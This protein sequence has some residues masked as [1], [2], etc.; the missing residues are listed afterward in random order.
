MSRISCLKLPSSIYENE[1]VQT[2]DDAVFRTW[3]NILS[4]RAEIRRF[5]SVERI[6]SFTHQ[7]HQEIEAHITALIK[8]GLFAIDAKGKVRP[9]A[10]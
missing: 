10:L 4:I 7:D 9:L 5:P 8:Q 2:L 1:K 6:A 3:L